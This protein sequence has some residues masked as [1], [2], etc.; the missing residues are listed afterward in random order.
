MDQTRK[1]DL[2]VCGPEKPLADGLA[3]LM[4][5]EG[6]Q[7]IGPNKAA[8]R[9]EASKTFAKKH[10]ESKHTNISLPRNKSPEEAWQKCQKR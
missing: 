8:A 1:I 4:Q 10:D 2:T 7:I 6:L 9:L 5:A 3:D